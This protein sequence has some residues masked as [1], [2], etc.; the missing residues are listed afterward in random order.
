MKDI[1]HR[2]QEQNEHL[3]DIFKQ[4]TGKSKR[5]RKYHPYNV[6]IYKDKDMYEKERER[7]EQ[8]SCY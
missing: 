7:I 1:N 4:T 6:K 3:E 5:K 8:I 2:E